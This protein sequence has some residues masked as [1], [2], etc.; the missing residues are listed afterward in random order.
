MTRR[1]VAA[2]VA[3]V[4]A[5]CGQAE[6]GRVD[7]RDYDSFWL[8]AGVT[9]P[10]ELAKARTIYLLDGE[11]RTGAAYLPLRPGTPHLPGKALWL[12]VRTDTLDWPDSAIGGLTG[13]LD[14]WAA[15][16]NRVEGLQLDF[17]A[18]TKHLDDYAK[19]LRSVRIALPRRYKLSITGLLDGSANGDPRV[20][21]SL[22]GVVEEVVVQTYQGRMTI[23]GYENYFAGAARWSVPFKVGLVQN[24]L[25]TAPASLASAPKF[26]GY[27]VFLLRPPKERAAL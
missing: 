10:P 21:D 17:D 16:G 23:P 19:F 7:P 4:L 25:W 14:R 15:A 9:P 24:G 6:R 2:A 26:R 27:V 12:V 18:R 11:L 20:L 13:R 1:W 22:V 8:W 5:G 3:L